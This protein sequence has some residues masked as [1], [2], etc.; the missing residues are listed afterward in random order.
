MIRRLKYITFTFALVLLFGQCKDV[1]ESPYVAPATGYLVVEGFIAGNGPTQVRLSR[2][3]PLPGNTAPAAEKNAQLQVE[4]EDNTSYVLSEKGN[5]LYGIDTLP[6]DT[7]KKYR[8]RIHTAGNKDYLSD[9]TPFKP[10]PL[11]DSIS[12]KTTSTGVDIFANTHDATGS[13]RYYQWEY[14]ETWRYHSAEF[15]EGIYKEPPPSVEY[16]GDAD[17]IYTCWRSTSSTTLLLGTSAKL[18]QDVIFEHLIN[19]VAGQSSQLSDLYSILVRQY[20]LTEDAYNYLTLMKKNSESLGSIFDAQPSKLKG[21][22]H[23]LS[24]PA[25]Q[26]IG[27]ISAGT[28]Q[29]KRIFIDRRQLPLLFSYYFSCPLKDTLTPP[30]E[31][32]YKKW[33][34]PSSGYTPV[35][36]HFNDFGIFDGWM[37]N[38]TSCIDCRLQGGTTTK[39]P[40]WP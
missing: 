23:G 8:L 7:G 35:Y 21:N 9:Y 22:I 19:Q 14:A 38:N 33:F 12:W 31:D 1:Y 25:E 34:S 20:T 5:G 6:L 36:Q 3:F 11:I 24:N 26:V 2:T 37:A 13:S 4:G 29:Q 18:S 17:Q 32:S 39:P 40:F 27:F 15:S 16:R 10:T 30:N 28:I